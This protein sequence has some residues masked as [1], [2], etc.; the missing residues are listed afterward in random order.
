MPYCSGIWWYITWLGICVLMTSRERA[1]MQGFVR[2]AS[3][4]NGRYI[5]AGKMAHANHFLFLKSPTRVGFCAAPEGEGP[6]VLRY[7]SLTLEK[8]LIEEPVE[9]E[10]VKWVNWKEG[11]LASIMTFNWAHAHDAHAPVITRYFDIGGGIVHAV[12]QHGRH[13]RL[14]PR[15]GY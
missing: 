10:K 12:P 3:Y 7:L 8:E 1:I 15:L 4:N 6:L 13:E 5:R 2:A 11:I 9:I 14:A